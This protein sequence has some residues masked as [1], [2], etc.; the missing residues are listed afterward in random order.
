MS[1]GV[2]L[3][4]MAHVVGRWERTVCGRVPDPAVD[5]SELPAC[6]ICAAGPVSLAPVA[7][8]ARCG[9]NGWLSAG[10]DTDPMWECPDCS[11]SG[12]ACPVGGPESPACPPMPE[13]P[14]AAAQAP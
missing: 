12:A 11:G 3:G 1:V 6:P 13:T 2:H 14:S 9:G 8:C 4:R 5:A 10:G 7:D